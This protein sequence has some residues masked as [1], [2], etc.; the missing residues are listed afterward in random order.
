METLEYD[1]ETVVMS[2]RIKSMFSNLKMMMSQW[3]YQ[4]K[5]N[6][7]RDTNWIGMQKIAIPIIK[8]PQQKRFGKNINAD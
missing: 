6:N 4:I 8:K 2:H 3:C 7:A 1:D 5:M